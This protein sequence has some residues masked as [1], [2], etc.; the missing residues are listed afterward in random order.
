MNTSHFRKT[1]RAALV[2]AAA[3]TAVT[4]AIVFSAGAPTTP[5]GSEQHHS[6]TGDHADR[7]TGDADDVEAEEANGANDDEATRAKGGPVL[8]QLPTG[9][10]PIS[11]RA[12]RRQVG[13]PRGERSV[14]S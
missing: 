10:L 5:T 13:V 9:D 1:V 3:A 11:G 4:T 12:T 7:N 2:T 6:Q 14:D 8:S